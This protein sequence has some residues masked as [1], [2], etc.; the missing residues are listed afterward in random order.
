[1]AHWLSFAIFLM[2]ISCQTNYEL[3]FDEDQKSKRPQID[4]NDLLTQKKHNLKIHAKS[5]IDH[6]ASSRRYQRVPA[7]IRKNPRL[8]KLVVDHFIKNPEIIDKGVYGKRGAITKFV[9]LRSDIP[10]NERLYWAQVK[11]LSE[12]YGCFIRSRWKKKNVMG[13]TCRDKRTIVQWKYYG[14]DYIGFLSRQFDKHGRPILVRNHEII[15]QRKGSKQL[16]SKQ[17]FIESDFL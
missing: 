2:M 14:D 10:T 15:N 9:A 6:G 17:Q 1:M 5:Y 12:K 11:T 8:S 16:F 13:F 3:K 4:W 7:T